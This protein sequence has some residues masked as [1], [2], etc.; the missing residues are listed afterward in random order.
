MAYR[1]YPNVDRAL[2]QL[3]RHYPGPPLVE[4]ECLRP[5]GDAFARLRESTRQA[6]AAAEAA[7]AYVLSTRRS[8]E[9][10]PVVTLSP[11]SVSPEVA[12]HF[13]AEFIEQVNRVRRPGAV[14]G[15]S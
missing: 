1:P 13:P 7:G 15:P 12:S 5:M 10:G 4:L 2:S 11:G 3:G 14:S 6:L 8:T 9:N